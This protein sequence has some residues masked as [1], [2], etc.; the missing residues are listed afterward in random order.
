MKEVSGPSVGITLILVA[1][2]IPVA[3][4]GGLVGQLYQ[5]FALTIAIS[6]IISAFNALT[7]EPRALGAAA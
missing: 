3:F 5:Q 7:L 6:V 4:L 2:F 1:V